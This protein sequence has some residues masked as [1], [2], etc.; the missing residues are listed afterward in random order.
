MSLKTIL[1]LIFYVLT[2]SP[3]LLAQQQVFDVGE[4]SAADVKRDTVS[5]GPDVVKLAEIKP[6]MKVFDLLGGGGYYSEILAQA[7]GKQGRVYLHN[8]KAYMPYVEKELVARLAKGRLTN[9]HRYD[10]EVDDLGIKAGSF[11]ALFFV[12]G[13]HDIYHQAEGWKIDRD[14]LLK[15]ITTALKPNG[16]LV[17]VDH[18]AK[19]GTGTKA[20]QELH[21]I[22]VAY[23]KNEIISLGFVLVAESDMLSNPKDLRTQ[24][25]FV[26]EMRRK[27][28]RFVLVFKKS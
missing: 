7:V 2:H 10:R 9:V 25:P 26:P 18:S 21:R 15:Q 4:R 20:S 22:D 19:P 6:G 23:V 12:L 5:K 28:D 11:D 1:P 24:T 3:A 27:T 13:Y 16:K 8:N 17:I 14:S